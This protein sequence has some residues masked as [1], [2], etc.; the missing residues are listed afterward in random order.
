M[1][2]C[3][4][5]SKEYRKWQGKCDNCGEWNTLAEI[6]IPKSEFLN[7]KGKNSKSQI[8]KESKP[9]KLSELN[10]QTATSLE[11]TAHSSELKT[12]ISEFDNAIGGRFVR[13]QV[14]LLA[15]SPG[16]GKS[17][18][19]L[20]I[21]ESF[22]NSNFTV[23]YISGEESPEQ[24]KHRVDRLKQKQ[25]NVEFLQETNIE[26]IEN[27]M[28]TNSSKYQVIIVDSI[29]TL[30]SVNVASSSG[31]ISQVSECADRIIN[32]S[33]G[34]GIISII[35]GHINKSGNIAGPKILEHMVDTVL[36]FEGDKSHEFRLLRVEKNRYGSTDEVGLFKMSENGLV[37]VQD[38]KELFDSNKIPASGSVFCM[39]MEGKRAVVVEVQALAAK[40]Y[41]E[42]PRRTT[43]GFD[44]S[45]LNI[46]LALTDKKLK[47]KSY[48]YDI[49]VNIT[50]GI[51]LKDPALDLAVLKAIVSSIQD[52]VVSNNELYFG[53]VGLTG[54]VRKVM[55][56]E[57]REKEAKRL[58]FTKVWDSGSMKSVNDI[59]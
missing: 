15:G 26:A 49:Y 7:K 23:L 1:Y 28:A 8:S 35:I 32:L 43:S 4:N 45:R 25:T 50:G 19:S 9:I 2:K 27:Y 56:Q 3:S 47:L 48:E 59:V 29:Q 5:C 58:G 34:F 46:L 21:T 16:I 54:E 55:F 38:T 24:I 18:L 22:S 52:K 36:Y 17:T 20:Q 12:G 13:G 39:A 31:S 10:K 57:K 53:E 6:L 14:L 51:K 44:L 40:T 42:I 41:F 30:Y 33:K 37:E 11:P